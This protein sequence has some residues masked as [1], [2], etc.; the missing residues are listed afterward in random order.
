MRLKDIENVE[1]YCNESGLFKF[2]YTSKLG[3]GCTFGELGLLEDKPR[4]AMIICS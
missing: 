4:S 3:V 2:A 1:N